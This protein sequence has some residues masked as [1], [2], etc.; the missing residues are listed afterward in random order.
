MTADKFA[1]WPGEPGIRLHQLIDGQPV[2]MSPTTLPHGR[3]Q[4][5]LATRLNNHLAAHRPDC[6]VVT[7]PGVQ[8]GIDPA[9]NVRVPDLAVG[10]G[11]GNTRYL[12]DPVL[13]VEILSPSNARETREAVRACLTIR[14]LREVLILSSEAIAAEV[15]PRDAAGEW[16]AEPRLLGPGDTLRLDSLGFGCAMDE[17]YAGLGL[18]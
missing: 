10:C 12:P 14:S 13:I 2:A 11:L 17:L 3:L 6:E 15:Y 4:A 7:K 8:P 9:H 16:P 1:D 18:G 5:R